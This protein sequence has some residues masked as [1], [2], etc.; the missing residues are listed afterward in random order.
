MAPVF[1]FYFDVKKKKWMAGRTRVGNAAKSRCESSVFSTIS[2][3]DLSFYFEA[4]ATC[5]SKV[6][7]Q[8][9]ISHVKWLPPGE[10][11]E[12]LNRLSLISLLAQ[13]FISFPVS[14]LVLVLAAWSCDLSSKSKLYFCYGAA[15]AA[16]CHKGRNQAISYSIRGLLITILNS[17]ISL[18]LL[19]PLL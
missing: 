1:S 9:D 18:L 5:C 13:F 17:S 7:S 12:S 19:L 11:G 14:V 3:F 8:L 4:T 2:F 10:R 6:T 15:R 16:V